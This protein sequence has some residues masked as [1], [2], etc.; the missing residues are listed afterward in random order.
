MYKP[1]QVAV[2]GGAAVITIEQLQGGKAALAPS[3]QPDGVVWQVPKRYRSGMINSWWAGGGQT[4]QP[5]LQA[6]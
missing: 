5:Q 2:E 1:E 6:A 3:Q 4:G